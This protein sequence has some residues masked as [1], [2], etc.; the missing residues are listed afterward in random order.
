LGGND[1]SASDRGAALLHGLVAI[2]PRRDA[3]LCLEDAAKLGLIVEALLVGDLAD[4][5]LAGRIAECFA[6]SVQALVADPASKRLIGVAEQFMQ[7]PR[8]YPARA[9]DGFRSRPLS[10]SRPRT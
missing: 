2:F 1:G 3:K 10:P 4:G 6:A 5:L 8:R 7:V 9:C